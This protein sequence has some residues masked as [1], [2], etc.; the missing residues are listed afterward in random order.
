MTWNPIKGFWEVTTRME[1]LGVVMDTVEMKFY[2]A[3]LKVLRVLGFKKAD[4]SYPVE[5]T[6]V[7]TPDYA[8]LLWTIFCL[9]RSGFRWHVY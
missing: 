1:H 9:S 3:H 4:G 8:S 6:P 7:S 5:P 2:T